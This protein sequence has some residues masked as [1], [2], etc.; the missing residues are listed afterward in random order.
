MSLSRDPIKLFSE[1]PA[2]PHCKPEQ[3]SF[4]DTYFWSMLPVRPAP[5]LPIWD[6]RV[7]RVQFF[8]SITKWNFIQPLKY[9]DEVNR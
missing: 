8:N 2:L 1:R 9:F 7:A 5:T 6:T 4:V 3:I